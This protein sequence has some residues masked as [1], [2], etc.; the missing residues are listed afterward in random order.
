MYTWFIAPETTSYRFR[1]ACNL[2]CDLKIGL[3]AS[4]PLNT[5]LM[6]SRRHASGRRAHMRL[7]GDTVTDW[8]NFTKG[9]KYY[10]YAKHWDNHGSDYMTVGVEINQTTM[11]NHHHSMK[12]IQY[13][14]ATVEN[15]TYD[16]MRITHGDP[17][18]SGKYY[19]TF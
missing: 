13:I 7:I 17:S 4:D 14:E 8:I 15:A 3:N 19:L 9:E 2:Y 11:V 12:E 5:T 1:M 18:A 16:T 6:A 10:M